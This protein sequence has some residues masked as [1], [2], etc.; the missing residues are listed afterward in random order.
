M[1]DIT[2]YLVSK[3]LAGDNGDLARAL[4]MEVIAQA[5]VVVLLNDP[6]HL[7][8]SLGVN[9]AHLDG[10]LHHFLMTVQLNA[11]KVNKSNWKIHTQS[12]C[13]SYLVQIGVNFIIICSSWKS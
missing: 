1:C 10:P 13:F 5:H 11:Q 4:D 3:L 12:L 6:D 7:L 2:H 8:H 9:M